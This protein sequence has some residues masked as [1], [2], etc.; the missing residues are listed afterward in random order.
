[1]K[2]QLRIL[3]LVLVFGVIGFLSSCSSASIS[4]GFTAEIDLTDRA[5]IRG[6][7]ERLDQMQ[8]DITGDRDVEDIKCITAFG[9]GAY[10]VGKKPDKGVMCVTPGGYKLKDADQ[11]CYLAFGPEYS[12]TRI[13]RKPPVIHCSEPRTEA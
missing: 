9:K 6:Y 8:Y 5:R 10:S 1:M 11:F 13:D 3:G 4:P 12:A 7:M 2:R